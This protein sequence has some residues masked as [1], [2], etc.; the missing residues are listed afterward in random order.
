LTTIGNEISA[1][2]NG[3]VSDEINEDICKVNNS[4]DVDPLPLGIPS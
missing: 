2:K 3:V 4:I 1:S